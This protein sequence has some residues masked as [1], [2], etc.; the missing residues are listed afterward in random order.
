MP[1]YYEAL[2]I[3]KAAME[4]AVLVDTVVQR[5]AKGHKYTLGGRLR[6]T[7]LDIVGKHPSSRRRGLS[8]AALRLVSLSPWPWKNPSPVAT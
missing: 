2:P 5:F 4:L 3:Y 6:E 1:S 8:S 7:A